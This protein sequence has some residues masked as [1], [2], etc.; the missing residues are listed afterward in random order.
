MRKTNKIISLVLA[1]ALLLGVFVVLPVTPVV[2]NAAD[3]AT[4][5]EAPTA[6]EKQNP[7]SQ[8]IKDATVI[9]NNNYSGS[10][11]YESTN[12][13]QWL[14]TDNATGNQYLDIRPGAE[15]T[16][17]PEVHNHWNWYAGTGGTAEAETYYQQG[18][19]LVVEL[20]VFVEAELLKDAYLVL[21]SRNSAGGKYGA[22]IYFSN[23]GIPVGEWVHLTIIGDHDVDGN[24]LNK[25]YYFV[26]GAY[27]YVA[28][29]GLADAT[30]TN[31]EIGNFYFDGIRL[32]VNTRTNL[33]A[34]QN[35][36]IDN[37]K[38]TY[39]VESAWLDANLSSAQ[40]LKGSDVYDANYALPSVPTLA[41]V[42]G[43]KV[44]TPSALTT[45]L[46]GFAAKNVELLRNYNGTVTVNC[47]ATVKTN[48]FKA[49]VAG[50]NVTVTAN[51]GT[52]TY[53]APFRASLSSTGFGNVT[54][55][56]NA[57]I[58]KNVPGNMLSSVGM[59]NFGGDYTWEA[60]YNTADLVTNTADGNFYMHVNGNPNYNVDAMDSYTN[61]PASG[62][63]THNESNPYYSVFEFDFA[64]EDTVTKLTI[65]IMYKYNNG[66]FAYGSSDIKD[67][68]NTLPLEEFHRITVI[69]DNAN[70]KSYVFVD[71]LLVR[72]YDKAVLNGASTE[73]LNGTPYTFYGV[74]LAQDCNQTYNIDN[75]AVRVLQGSQF[76]TAIT[77]GNL[78]SWSGAITAPKAS[79]PTIAIVDG[80]EVATAADLSALLIG[81]DNKN[82]EIL[83]PYA[84]TVTVSCDAVI[85]THGY[86]VPV[87]ATGVTATNDG[88]V[89]TYDAP[90]QQSSS[91]ADTNNATV[92]LN[93][94]KGDLTGNLY[95]SV[96]GN[97]W[98]GNDGVTPAVTTNTLTGDEYVTVRLTDDEK[99]S[100]AYVQFTSS[101]VVS[102]DAT[103]AQYIVY[104]LDVAKLTEGGTIGT[105]NIVRLKP[106]AGGNNVGPLNGGMA[107]FGA[108]ET[109]I[110]TFHHYTYVFDITNNTSQ[111]F[112]DGTLVH[113][114]KVLDDTNFGKFKTGD[115]YDL[116]VEGLRYTF[117]TDNVAS[118]AFDNVNIRYISTD[119]GSAPA[120]SLAAA[121]AASNIA[122][123]S[124]ACISAG[125]ELAP[126]AT[127]DGKYVATATQLT[128]ALNAYYPKNVEILRDETAAITVNCDA[129]INTN[130][131]NVNLVAGS[132]VTVSE[133]G[134]VKTYDAPWKASAS[135]ETTDSISGAM[136]GNVVGNLVNGI[137]VA[138]WDQESLKSEVVTDHETTN[139]FVTLTSVANKT[140]KNHFLNVD[141]G[142]TVDFTNAYVFDI[143]VASSSDFVNEMTANFCI[144]GAAGVNKPYDTS[145]AAFGS[146]VPNDGAWHH[147]TVV[148]DTANNVLYTFVDGT[149]VDASLP[150]YNAANKVEG[151]TPSLSIRINIGANVAMDDG[152]D[153]SFDNISLRSLSATDAGLVAALAAGDLDG[154]DA[155]IT[156]PETEKLPV[157]AVVDGKIC[158]NANEV[159]AALNGGSGHVVSLERASAATVAAAGTATITTHG[160]ANFISG[161]LGY[162]VVDNGDGTCSVIFETRYG[163]VVVNI[164]GSEAIRASLLYG[165][166]IVEYLNENNAF[167][168]HAEG[169][170]G[171]IAADNGKLYYK[172]YWET[173]PSGVVNGD[174][175]YSLSATEFEGEFLVLEN[176]AQRNENNFAQ[177]LTWNPGGSGR[178]FDILLNSDIVL[179]IGST[180]NLNV[181]NGRKYIYLN[182]HTISFGTSGASTHA[183]SV[184]TKVDIKFIGGNI[185][186]NVRSNTQALFYAD[187]G[188][189]GTAEFVNCNLYTVANLATMRGGTLTIKDSNVT[190]LE[191]QGSYGISLCEYYNAG[192]TY[193][194][195]TVNLVDSDIR[196]VH[197][198]HDRTERFLKIKDITE[199]GG[200]TDETYAEAVSRGA[201]K[202]VHEINVSGCTVNN[203]FNAAFINSTTDNV[204]IT[205]TDTQLNVQS[206]FAGAQGDITVGEGVV[207]AVQLAH[208]GAGI[209][210]VKSGN[211]TAPYLY[212]AYYATVTWADGTVEYWADGSYPVNANYSKAN[213]PQVAAGQSYVIGDNVSVDISMKANLS[214]SANLKLNVYVPTATDLTAMRIAGVVYDV[215][216]ATVVQIDG[217]DYYYFA[218][219]MA[220]QYATG[221]FTVVATVGETTVA[222]SIDLIEYADLVSAQYAGNDAA[223]NLAKA[224]LT[225]VAA[226][227]KHMG[228]FSQ[229][230]YATGSYADAPALTVDAATAVNTM[231]NVNDYLTGAAL[232]LNSAPAWVFYVADGADISDLVVKV[233]GRVVAHTVAGN[234]VYVELRAYDMIETLTVEVGGV[235]GEYNFA[236][237]YTAMKALN[238]G[239]SWSSSWQAGAN[240]DGAIASHAMQL[241]DAFYAYAVYAAAVQ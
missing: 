118:A 125:S 194:K 54:N 147:V 105:M 185:V 198:S 163:T 205:I 168:A 142:C 25:T 161:A 203:A 160:L 75:V 232:D 231:A 60:G 155:A 202:L 67:V 241:L 97:V 122:L 28:N 13:S 127:V 29:K 221:D 234:K 183:M 19:Y 115:T 17:E 209:K 223:I 112:R 211:P 33:T 34:N 5:P 172:L 40:S 188:F 35:L 18:K 193:N 180:A 179:N 165:T 76:A 6:T 178:A 207:S 94:T 113:S 131:L 167:V 46:S 2:S 171:A 80:K 123:W 216:A 233:N 148:G 187:Y 43:E 189:S 186:D 65:Q 143:D 237:Y 14:V 146:F 126:L 200:K 55:I 93:A 57:I 9:G 100:N 37:V 90:Y 136:K 220:P 181:D 96:A 176:G 224:V 226:A 15:F 3:D 22:G 47:D 39:N 83:R 81:N 10:N 64:R 99:N 212:T 107:N 104:D 69:G 102:Y 170:R 124:D 50:T 197:G 21:M 219:E 7:S 63:F 106:Q 218:Y 240:N 91:S 24:G 141:T 26:N 4:T 213:I 48:D 152:D 87:A 114:A 85:D 56:A 41:I 38:Y 201:D 230:Y 154:W 49:P 52:Y 228:T 117:T 31:D 32:N 195:V 196:F 166:D 190:V 119:I 101:T 71:G 72:T 169:G 156:E 132:G 137:G 42:D 11:N 177:F 206:L 182:G 103:K 23:I 70:D 77:A 227:A 173:A 92:I 68:L 236:A 1:L 79:Y 36:A 191:T 174:V 153:I 58:D 116:L 88:T 208:L 151:E 109:D 59:Q 95:N 140:T 78:Y 89:Y 225:Y 199:W 74:R 51:A 98:S 159:A 61:L 62:E 130:G 164:N 82:V 204:K 44:Y 128:D 158:Y 149:L 73:Y 133:N 129:V 192:Y 239:F 8:E 215:A 214:L 229:G 66:S 53:D 238:D 144:R 27:T 16:T 111:I 139:T 210:E 162:N 134:D 12:M 45:L 135:A 121:Y 20:D 30:T 222:K 86:T 138:N 157:L 120:G 145:T 217:V 108:L 184:S 150:A 110:G 235:S 84:G 175:T